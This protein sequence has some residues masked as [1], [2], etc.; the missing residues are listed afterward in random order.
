MFTTKRDNRVHAIDT[1]AQTY[2]VIYDAEVAQGAAL[3]GVDNITVEEGS[4]DLFVAE[5]GDDMQVVIITPEGEGRAPFA[6]VT[7][8]E[9]SRSRG[10]RSAPT[11]HGSTSAPSVAPTATGSPTR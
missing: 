6:Q 5:D 3:R 4:G 9:N 8:H 2:R 11:E 1:A 7:G 10:L